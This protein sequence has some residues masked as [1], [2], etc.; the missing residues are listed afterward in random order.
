MEDFPHR[1]DRKKKELSLQSKTEEFRVEYRDIICLMQS[2][3]L[4][5]L[6]LSVISISPQEKMEQKYGLPIE[7]SLEVTNFDLY[8]ADTSLESRQILQLSPLTLPHFYSVRRD[9]CPEE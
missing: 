4:C 1:T 7:L 8:S 9:K 2:L 5:C 3:K 6:I